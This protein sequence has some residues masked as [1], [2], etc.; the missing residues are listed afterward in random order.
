MSEED[1]L[2]DVPEIQNIS[3]FL[4][5]KL[6]RPN[7]SDEDIKTLFSNQY[8]KVSNFVVFDIDIQ[9]DG[10]VEADIGLSDKVE[11]IMH[12][13]QKIQQERLLKSL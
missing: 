5:L 7:M 11:A 12:V 10:N 8:G 9:S 1:K 3:V 13:L 6:P 4:N 2:R